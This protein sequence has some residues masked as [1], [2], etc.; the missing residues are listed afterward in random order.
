MSAALRAYAAR[1][2]MQRNIDET[3]VAPQDFFQA[4]KSAEDQAPFVGKRVLISGLMAR[5]DLN[6]KTG[7]CISFS[8]IQGRYT[9]NIDG[10]DIALK[11]ANLQIIVAN[12]GDEDA[13]SA[14][15]RV[16]IKNLSAKPEL[17]GSGASV[18]EWNAEKGRF[19]IEIDGSMQR[20]LLRAANLE[21]DRRERW[22]PEM[23]TVA[24]MQHINAEQEAYI[25]A[26]ASKNPF[27]EM[28]GQQGAEM[29]M[30]QQE[31]RNAERAEQAEG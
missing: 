22:S 17:N 12:A 18:V 16:K 10:T 30:K 4:S 15:S 24:N 9:V 11:A 6:G 28:F 3:K 13:F 5:T 29:L 21:R 8:S 2:A 27:S 7:E 26:Q 20:M 19:V 25:R 14:G 23:H 31:D 1:E